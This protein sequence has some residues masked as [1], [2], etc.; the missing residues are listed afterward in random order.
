MALSEDDEELAWELAWEIEDPLSN[1]T[2]QF[3]RAVVRVM[4]LIHQQNRVLATQILHKMITTQPDPVTSAHAT[5]TDQ[6]VRLMLEQ[7]ERSA[8]GNR[9]GSN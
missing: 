8:R 4:R 3:A 7:I 2:L 5:S 6:I 1:E 9:N